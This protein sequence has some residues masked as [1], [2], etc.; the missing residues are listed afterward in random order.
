MKYGEILSALNGSLDLRELL[1][2]SLFFH[3]FFDYQK[4]L[5]SDDFFHKIGWVHGR[6][7]SLIEDHIKRVARNMRSSEAAA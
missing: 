1:Y 7:N 4:K 6:L 3:Q 2:T 5:K